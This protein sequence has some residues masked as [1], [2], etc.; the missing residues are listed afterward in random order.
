MTFVSGY[1]VYSCAEGFLIQCF[2][3]LD[4]F[5]FQID[6]RRFLTK[7]SDI[8]KTLTQHRLSAWQARNVLNVFE[9]IL[10]NKALNIT[11][12]HSKYTNAFHFGIKLYSCHLVNR[13]REMASF[14]ISKEIEKDFLFV[15]R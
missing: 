3:C 7:F 2:R 9:I 5:D 13:R 12:H 14:E 11:E 6:E 8:I 1:T 10:C 4:F 15:P